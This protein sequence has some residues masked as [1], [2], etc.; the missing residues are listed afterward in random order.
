MRIRLPNGRSI[1]VSWQYSFDY[2]RRAILGGYEQKRVRVTDCIVGLYRDE[3]STPD[4]RFLGCA[5]QHVAD[6]DNKYTA[7]K[8]SLRSALKKTVLE[9]NTRVPP[10]WHDVLE[11]VAGRIAPSTREKIWRE[12]HASPVLPAVLLEISADR[13]SIIACDGQRMAVRRLRRDEKSQT[14]F[15]VVE[16]ATPYFD[17]DDDEAHAI[18]RMLLDRLGLAAVELAMNGLRPLCAPS[19]SSKTKK[20]PAAP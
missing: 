14:P 4:L 6:E 18:L 5:L 15:D 1:L 20:T 9:E 13:I 7:R 11:H 10:G 19:S 8:R 2:A 17:G 3:Q 16:G 12:F